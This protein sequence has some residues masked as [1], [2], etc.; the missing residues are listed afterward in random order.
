MVAITP[1]ACP[2]LAACDA[3]IEAA[4][5][6]KF[7][8]RKVGMGQIGRP[9]ERE[10]WYTLRQVQFQRFDADSI[11]RFDDGHTSEAV[12]VARLK[13]T[14]GVE[15]HSVD[16]SGEQY[17]FS[18]FGGHF[19]GAI[20]GVILGLV[21][22]PKTWHVLEIKCSTKWNEIDKAR[23]KVGEKH[24]LQEWNPI[25]YAQA[26][27]YMHYAALDRHYLVSCSPGAR[28][29]TA[30]RTNADPAHAAWLRVKAERIIFADSPPPRIGEPSHFV[31]RF[32][33]HAAIC[34]EGKPARRSCR[35]CLHVTPC[36]TGG[37]RCEHPDFPHEL[38]L[39]DQKAGCPAH[40]FNP[41]LVPGEQ[42]DAGPHGVTYRMADTTEWTDHGQEI[43]L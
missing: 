38:S 14:P 15:L 31:C 27:L 6:L 39:D 37:W 42:I 9:C 4:Q 19:S 3:A 24:A 29:W 41:G 40:R 18:D 30:V 43:A 26:V 34:H 17:R 10:I 2:T 33:D 21:Q 20:D 22:A 1:P 8:N 13:K 5:E 16:A 32:C 36:R 12:A 23:A 7:R 28:R 25:Y 11:K 35:T